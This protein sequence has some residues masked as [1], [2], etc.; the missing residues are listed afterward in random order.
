VV[1]IATALAFVAWFAAFRHLRTGSVGL[2]GLLNPVTGLLLGTIVAA[3]PITAV[4][5]G[6]VALVFAGILAGRAP[7][8]VGGALRDT[9]AAGDQRLEH[10]FGLVDLEARPSVAV[11]EESD[12]FAVGTAHDTKAA[13]VTQTRHGRPIGAASRSV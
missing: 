4:Q 3:E 11:L 2:I 13:D 12:Q 7:K 1:V 8:N 6:G 9:G 10:E 5:L